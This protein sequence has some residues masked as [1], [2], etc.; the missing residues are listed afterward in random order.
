MRAYWE[1]AKSGFRRYSRYRTAVAASAF[2]NTVFG[3]IRASLLLTAIRIA[4]R[5]VG[6]YDALQ[7]ATYV[8]LGQ[9]LLGPIDIWGATSGEIGER[10]KSGDI[11]VDLLR[12]TSYLG[13]LWATNMGRAAFEF[14]P[15]ALPPLIIGALLT[16]LYV[17]TSPLAY[18]LGLVS[19]IMAT[20]LCLFFFAA[21]QLTALWFVENRGFVN[22]IVPIQQVLS[23]FL[24]PVGWFPGWLLAIATFSPFPSMFQT[25]VDVLTERLRGPSLLAGLAVQ[26]GWTIL[27]GAGCAAM[28]RAGRRKLVIQGG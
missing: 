18:A 20:T 3:L 7:A 23:G 8:W 1:L 22:V 19:L 17:P 6:G 11:A 4:G 10:V 28:L 21:V 26:A 13:Q 25:T 14:L 16:G 27:A 12:P 5:P 15:R 9:A 24:V 2:T